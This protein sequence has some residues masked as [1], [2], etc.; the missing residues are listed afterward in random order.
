M[1]KEFNKLFKGVIGCYILYDKDFNVIYVGQSN[2]IQRRILCHVGGDGRGSVV[3]ESEYIVEYLAVIIEND[4]EQRGELEYQLIN[5]LNPPLN[6]SKE[7]YV[8]NP[9]TK[10]MEKRY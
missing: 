4:H 1:F 3:Y 10:K 8:Y 5:R 2:N 7:K 9:L 6:T